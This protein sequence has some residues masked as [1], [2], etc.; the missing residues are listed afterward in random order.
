MSGFHLERKGR[1][2]PQNSRRPT[3]KS[4]MTQSSLP[5]FSNPPVVEVA[6]GLQFEPLGIRSVHFGQFSKEVLDATWPLASDAPPI[7]DQFETFQERKFP[8]P[9]M[10]FRMQAGPIVNRVQFQNTE[11]DR[12]I[13]VQDTR[14][15]YNWIWKN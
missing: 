10:S 3:S 4:T 14:S 1:R 11:R 6:I 5:S 9:N 2:K 15:I 8:W 13:Q 12:M 7:P